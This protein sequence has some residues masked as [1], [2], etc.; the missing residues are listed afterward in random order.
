MNGL[1]LGTHIAAVVALV[2]NLWAGGDLVEAWIGHT[3]RSGFELLLM[4]GYMVFVLGIRA[5]LA[6]WRRPQEPPGEPPRPDRSRD[7]RRD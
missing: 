6:F 7:D 2:I 1:S 4:L 5:P 3:A